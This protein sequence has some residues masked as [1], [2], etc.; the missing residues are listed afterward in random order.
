MSRRIC[1]I[2]YTDISNMFS[3]T[4]FNDRPFFFAFSMFK[5]Y[6]ERARQY[7]YTAFYR[8]G[9]LHL[10]F[11]SLKNIKIKT[12]KKLTFLS[13]LCARLKLSNCQERIGMEL[14][15]EEGGS[16]IFCTYVD[17]I[18]APICE[19]HLFHPPAHMNSLVISRSLAPMSRRCPRRI[20]IGEIKSRRTILL[21][22]WSGTMHRKNSRSE[23]NTQ[24][25]L[26]VATN[27]PNMKKELLKFCRR[28]N[29]LHPSAS[30]HGNFVQRTYFSTFMYNRDLKFPRIKTELTYMY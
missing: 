15:G 7:Y 1:W 8:N 11:C 20:S 2:F 13:R 21:S 25:R 18:F 16:S 19:F 23:D 28:T 9:W 14:G 5:W 26:L 3:Y 30:A 6:N 29:I 12:D 17:E 22:T 27:V 10:Y 24:K 4:P